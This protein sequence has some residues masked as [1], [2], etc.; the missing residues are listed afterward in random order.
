MLI[1]V[2]GFAILHLP[3]PSFVEDVLCERAVR[4]LSNMHPS[5][6]LS[7]H[8]DE[9]IKSVL[10][11]GYEA[12]QQRE[13]LPT[14]LIEESLI[15]RLHVEDPF[16]ADFWKSFAVG[17]SRMPPEFKREILLEYLEYRINGGEFF[18]HSAEQT[19]GMAQVLSLRPQ[20]YRF[21][22]SWGIYEYFE[23]QA[24]HV[25]S[26][27][28]LDQN[29]VLDSSMYAEGGGVRGKIQ[30][31]QDLRRSLAAGLGIEESTKISMTPTVILEQGMGGMRS[32]RRH[33]GEWGLHSRFQKLMPD[34]DV[35]LID[36]AAHL[37]EEMGVGR[38]I[39]SVSSGEPLNDDWIAAEVLATG[40]T[41][42]TMDR[43]LARPFHEFVGLDP[44]VHSITRPTRNRTKVF[45]HWNLELNV[46]V[47]EWR[48]FNHRFKSTHVPVMEIT[49]KDLATDKIYFMK[50]IQLRRS[51]VTDGGAQ[52]A[53]A[54]PVPALP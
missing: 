41:F 19:L 52:P 47:N 34:D 6:H 38:S 39:G 20:I 11:E 25:P 33:M 26:A 14:G 17:Y 28:A 31:Y 43:N 10:R 7:E 30:W 37:F 46:Q 49:I 23:W 44:E 54:L 21:D 1:G 12:I 16:F 3:P 53:V 51:T 29:I 35:A 22:Q 8:R 42:L 18:E 48:S 50:L 32:V 13:F 9:R 2:L 40:A 5:S 27:E 45:S 4:V 15:E 24:N 36:R